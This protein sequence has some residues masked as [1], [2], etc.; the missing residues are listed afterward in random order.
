MTKPMR[1]SNDAYRI[2]REYA[3]KLDTSIPS[4]LDS[5]LEDFFG[6]EDLTDIELTV[7]PEEE[8]EPDTSSE[9]EDRK[10]GTNRIPI[11]KE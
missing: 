10:Y 5:I 1:V 9:E 4:V 8:E 11:L 6:A 3:D 2:L 7:E